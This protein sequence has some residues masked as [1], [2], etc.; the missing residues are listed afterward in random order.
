MLPES[1]GC[2]QIPL[3]RFQEYL[4]VSGYKNKVRKEVHRY[5]ELL[6]D[7]KR[8]IGLILQEEESGKELFQ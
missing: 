5:A 4:Q 8:A 3:L 7:A 1:N 6:M 2:A